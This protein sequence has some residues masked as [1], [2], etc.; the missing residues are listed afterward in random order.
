MAVD[1]WHR[2]VVQGPPGEVRAFRNAMRRRVVRTLGSS[3]WKE[4]VPFSF[5]RLYEIAPAARKVE[6]EIPYDAYGIRD[7]PVRVIRARLAEVRY[8]FHTRNLEMVGL[9]RAL[10]RARPAL[11]MTLMTMCLDDG[12]VESYRLARGTVKKWRVPQRRKDAHWEAARKKHRLAGHAVY[13]DEDATRF[14]EERIMAEAIDHWDRRPRKRQWWNVE[15]SRD[16]ETEREI[17]IC[18]MSEVT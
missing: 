6:E 1:W 5:E 13:D 14:A 12:D 4:V 8:Q 18:Q 15:P 3:S 9:I 16:L 17:A 2:L 10:S 11:V 7:W